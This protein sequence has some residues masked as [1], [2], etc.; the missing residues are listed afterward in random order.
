MPG[1]GGEARRP[2][3][4]EGT[5]PQ[6]PQPP[7]LPVSFVHFFLLPASLWKSPPRTLGS[8]GK[9]RQDSQTECK[10]GSSSCLARRLGRAET[11]APPVRRQVGS[12]KQLANFPCPVQ[13]V[14]GVPSPEPLKAACTSGPRDWSE[15][16]APPQPLPAVLLFLWF[17]QRDWGERSSISPFSSPFWVPK[18]LCGHTPHKALPWRSEDLPPLLV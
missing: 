10:G 11:R 18:G 4:R 5:G 7:P 2:G 13:R 8:M 1:G 6:P 9:L 15:D 16:E 14:G 12:R 3:L 17:P